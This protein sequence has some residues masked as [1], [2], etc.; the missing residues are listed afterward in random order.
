[1]E[2]KKILYVASEALPFASSGGLGDVIGSLPKALV[3]EMNER[4]DI[5]VVIPLYKSIKDEY[6][7][8]MTHIASI[9][10]P[11]AWRNQYCGIFS[12]TRDGVTFYFIDNE[13]YFARDSLYGSFDDGERF[14]FFCKAV[15]EILP[16]IDFFPDVLHAHDWQSA[17]S[18]IYLKRKYC[19]DSRYA[20]IKA[21]FTI[22]NIEYQ[23]IYGF[24]ILGDVFDLTQFDREIV[25][26]AGVIN[27]MKGAI[28]CADKVTTVSPRYAQEILTDTY[29]HGL[30]YVLSLYSKKL[31]GIL[32][33]IDTDYYDP[34][35]DPDVPVN[36]TWR[37]CGRKKE[38]KQI[39]QR[40]LGLPERD[41]PMIAIISRLTNHKGLDLV[42]WAAGKLLANDVQ[43]VVLGTGDYHF[44]QYFANLANQYSDKVSV[45]LR[46][47]KPL[48]KLIYASSD[49][50]LMP[51]KS[52]PCGLSQMIASRYGAVPI[53]RQAGGLFDTIHEDD[54][55]FTF[56]EYNGGEMLYAVNRALGYYSDAEKWSRLIIRVMKK[57]FSWD[58]SAKKYIEL[59]DG[60]IS[61]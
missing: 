30:H 25:E 45:T 3:R 39:L 52:E 8:Q 44:E 61:E 47:D 42:T 14:A 36:Y 40:R 7:R 48:S 37:S 23:G 43:L 26:Y 35:T 10:V 60:I 18:V 5:R 32:N 1:M 20:K 17:L 19:Y 24:E 38:N 34:H 13:F 29:S 57:D 27:L 6:R 55:G 33:G 31:C 4:S 50:F 59:Y 53:V 28:L 51:S 16:H 54:N 58:V 41:V 9:N 56:Y 11:L 21:V 15:M 46:F 49:M 12:L 2:R 22:H